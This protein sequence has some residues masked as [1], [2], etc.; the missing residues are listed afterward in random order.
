MRDGRADLEESIGE[1]SALSRDTWRCNEEEKRDQKGAKQFIVRTPQ[2]STDVPGKL[3]QESHDDSDS[4]FFDNMIMY[5]DVGRLE[6]G[7][8]GR[9]QR[10]DQVGLRTA[11]NTIQEGSNHTIRA[12]GDANDVILSHISDERKYFLQNLT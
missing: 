10:A 1:E 7:N 2:G 9:D 8:E 5:S 12:D 4:T 3:I 11:S 6:K